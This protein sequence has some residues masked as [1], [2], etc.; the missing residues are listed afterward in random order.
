[1][2]KKITGFLGQHNL[3]PYSCVTITPSKKEKERLLKIIS[4]DITDCHPSYLELLDSIFIPKHRLEMYVVEKFS[5]YYAYLFDR[6]NNRMDSVAINGWDPLSLPGFK[7]ITSVTIEYHENGE[8]KEVFFWS[9]FKDKS[10]QDGKRKV[11][12][13]IELH[14]NCR[15]KIN[16]N[17]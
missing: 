4:A 7:K 9:L 1:M 5:I 11:P 2:L 13:S 14:P 12:A 15:E 16:K 10:Y 6:T 3:Y 17:T 8:L